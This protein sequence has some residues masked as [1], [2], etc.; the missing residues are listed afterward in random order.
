MRLYYEPLTVEHADLIYSYT[1]DDDLY[2][3]I[4]DVKYPEREGLRQRFRQLAKGSGTLEEVWVN[5]VVFDDT[6]QQQPIG[7]L[8]A[9]IFPHKQTA[10]V[11]YIIFKDFWNKGY[12]TQALKW[13]ETYL[14]QQYAINNIEAYVDQNNHAS[15]RVLEKCHFKYSGCDGSDAVFSKNHLNRLDYDY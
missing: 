14:N 9:T 13:L 4:P 2:R 15:K 6:S 1:L 8:Q 3:F 5:W 10:Y 7:T 12:A 11:G